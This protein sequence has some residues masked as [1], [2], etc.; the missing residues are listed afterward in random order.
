MTLKQIAALGRKL[1]VFLALFADCFGRKEPREL[2]WL[3]V[4]GQFSDLRHKNAEAIAL[5]FGEAP[6]TLQ[7]FLESIK[8]DEEKLVDYTQKLVATQHAHSAA[9]GI[10]DESGVPK[11]GEHTAGVD[12]Q[13]CGNLG[14][15]DNCVVGVHLVYAAPGFQCLLGSRVYLPEDWANDPERRKQNHIPEEVQFRTKPQIALEQ[16]DRALGN[17]IAVAAWTCDEFY[18]RSSEFLDGLEQRRQIFVAEVPVSFHGWVRKP[19]VLRQGPKSGRGRRKKYPRLARKIPPSEVRNLVRYSPAFRDRSWQRY[20]IKDT[21]KGPQVWEIKWSV[22]WR[23]SGGGLPTRRQCLIVARN[24]LTGEE[25]YFVSNRV[26]GERGVTLRWLLRVAFGRWPVEQCFQQAKT[27][28]GMDHYQVRGWRCLHRHF[29][30][31]QLSYLFCARVRLEY[32]AQ[33]S[34]GSVTVEDVPASG[35][36]SRLTMEQVR[37]A[38]NAWLEAAT[39]TPKDRKKRYEDELKAIHYHQNRNQSAS[40]SHTRTKIDVFEFDVEKIKSCI[41]A[42]P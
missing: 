18:G 42:S 3:Y 38:I 26:P 22:F 2:L 17:G 19:R 15:V 31:T 9:I 11:S 33:E 30:L 12:R 24:V 23:K 10:I 37:G 20:R 32:D 28:L 13:W 25:K 27:E 34:A 1:T 40:Q 7:R 6:R 39:M 29:Y 8:W 5:K 4:R 16:I 36:R 35:H 41:P 21:T 14:K